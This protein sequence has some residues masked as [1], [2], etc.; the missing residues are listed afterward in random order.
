MKSI[1]VILSF[2]FIFSAK[3]QA[4]HIGC[5]AIDSLLDND[6]VKSYFDLLYKK[7]SLLLID[8]RDW[9]KG[10]CSSFQVGG[11]FMQIVN[12]SARRKKSLYAE[13]Y[14]WFKNDCKS[15][16]LENY[17][18]HGEMFYL[19]ILHPCNSLLIEAVVKWHKKKMKLVSVKKYV[20]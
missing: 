6:Q 9:L 11:N 2:L 19:T 7:D 13:P 18:Q 15:F 5:L 1:S 3:S 17:E 8:S 12:D 20:I 4:S 16:I 14:F 10:A